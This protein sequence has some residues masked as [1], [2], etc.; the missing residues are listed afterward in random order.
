MGGGRDTLRLVLRVESELVVVTDARESDLLDSKVG[1][2]ESRQRDSKVGPSSESRQRERRSDE[3]R[4][5]G[6]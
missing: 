1:P 4:E 6:V 3:D 2:S 5:E